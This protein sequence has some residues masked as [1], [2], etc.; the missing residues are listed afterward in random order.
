MKKNNINFL[1]YRFGALMAANFLLIIGLLGCRKD[2]FSYQEQNRQVLAYE[3]MKQDTSLSF[4]V[5]A[6]EKANLAPTLNTYGPFTFFAPDNNAFRKFF[7]SKGKTG[8]KVA[9][10][11]LLWLL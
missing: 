2:H 6:L 7:I 11:F 1:T 5:A 10:P 8:L 9:F 4:A 3:M